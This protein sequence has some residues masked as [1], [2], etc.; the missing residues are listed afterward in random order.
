MSFKWKTILGIAV[1][2]VVFLSFLVW[3][4]ASS[5]K[6]LGETDIEKRAT[7]TVSLASTV[8]RDSLIAY[9]LATIKEQIDQ[10]AA[11]DGVTYV[12]LNGHGKNLA[13]AFGDDV[14]VAG[15][16]SHISEVTDG[17]FD[18]VH[19]LRVAGQ[20]LGT[21]KIGFSVQ[22]LY[23]LTAQLQT[24]LYAIAI[25]ELVLVAF[26]SWWLA[27]YLTKRIL[28][29]RE[30]SEK[31]Q[32]GQSVSAIPSDGAD[33]ISETIAAFNRMSSALYEREQA[34]K[35]VNEK[36][37][38][39]NAKLLEQENEILSLFNSAPDSIAVLAPQGTVL[40]A[41]RQLLELLGTDDLSLVGGRLPDFI[42]SSEDAYLTRILNGIE[43]KVRGH[44]CRLVN[45]FGREYYAEINASVFHSGNSN[46]TILIIRDK[47][48][49]QKLQNQANLQERLKANLVDS[50]LDAIVTISG[51]E[52]VIDFSQSAESLFGWK[53]HE[54]LG[55]NMADFLIPED[56]K[57]AHEKGMKHFLDTGEGPLIGKRVETQAC[58]KGGSSFPVELALT[59]IWVDGEVFVTAAIRD[60]SERKQREEELV[61]AKSEAEEASKA[62][63]RFL[64]FMSHEIR[65]PMNAVLG[66]L[67][68]IQERGKLQESEQYYLDLARE[69]GDSLL[70]V[71]NEVLDFSKIEAGRVQFNKSPCVLSELIEGVQ[72]SILAKGAKPKVGMFF[73]LAEDIPRVVVLDRDHLRQV[74]TILLD[75]AYKFTDQ[76]EVRVIGEAVYRDDGSDDCGVRVMVRDTGHGIPPEMVETVFSEFEQT[77]AIR[78]SG[79]GGTGLGLA[80]AKRLV[81]GMGGTI[82]VK[83]QVGVG[84]TFIVEIPFELP[85][86]EQTQQAASR[87]EATNSLTPDNVL[88]PGTAQAQR[89]ILLVDDVEANLVIGSE[90]LKN[91]GYIVDLASNGAEAVESAQTTEY[92][93]ILMD[94][95]MPILNGLEATQKIRSSD[96]KNSATPIIALTANAE[97]SEIERCLKGGMNGFVSK[98]FD[99]ERLHQTI[100]DC[101]GEPA[102]GEVKMNRTDESD[103]ELE[104]LSE[105][106]LAQLTKDTSAESLPMMISVFVNEI[107]KRTEGI[108]NAHVIQ[109]E[110]EIREQAHALKSCSGTFGGLRLQAAAQHLEELASRSNAC[111]SPDAVAQVLKVAEKT[112][113]AYSEYRENLQA[114]SDSS[115]PTVH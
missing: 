29:L 84:S 101:L 47:T 10:I 112:L 44:S 70:K 63:S 81:A 15:P 90:L 34:L 108:E 32:A 23:S 9:D 111:A 99:I 88:H 78:D 85:S 65:S 60:I 59:A 67:A 42:T 21:L 2:E 39:S 26:C 14:N 75:N 66:S 76:G 107:K 110:I 72:S 64:S 80:I 6:D 105:T 33:E 61:K 83:S 53:K 79:F 1:I 50:S 62:K 97:K 58:R 115:D 3:Q 104:L 106:V 43:P 38:E 87:L 24:R 56:L 51:D 114:A 31:L 98:P 4:A 69:S 22:E 41:N 109:D 30:A 49:E 55:K 113:V 16:D 91:R 103:Q 35:I 45:C 12:Q 100:L 94:M 27:G 13:A 74:L 54:I 18:V 19:P 52:N 46:R 7:D 71:V 77:D 36:L 96:G 37:S 57:S 93:V 20:K 86:E 102:E 89:R 73:E 48:H 5:I 95:R 25:T 40:F 28:L 17:V 8:L 68:L 92:S 82:G 11:L